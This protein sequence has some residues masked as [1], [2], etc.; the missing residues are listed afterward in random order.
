MIITRAQINH[1]YVLLFSLYFLF[2]IFSKYSFF[3]EALRS[4]FEIMKYA[5]AFIFMLKVF[6]YRT[7]LNFIQ[8]YKLL[9]ISLLLL[10][11]YSLFNLIIFSSIT[12]SNIF[13]AFLLP[14]VILSAMVISEKINDIFIY[15]KLLSIFLVI[16]TMVIV[17]SILFPEHLTYTHYGTNRVRYVFG[18][19]K[20]SYFAETLVL[21]VY[22]TI[23]L[24]M[25]TKEI[26]DQKKYKIILFIMFSLMIL[27]DSRS[28]L[29][30]MIVF[31]LTYKFFNIRYSLVKLFLIVLLFIG[32]LYSILDFNYK[33]IMD[34]G[35]GRFIWWD[36]AI[37]N[38]IHTLTEELFGTGY[39]NAITN[40][41]MLKY[42]GNT[43]SSFH[44]DSFF[45]ETFIQQGYIGLILTFLV[46]F[47]MSGVQRNKL[48]MPILN[49]MVVYGLFESVIFHFATLFSLLTWI[50]FFYKDN[51]YEN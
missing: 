13:L 48:S 16:F 21:L 20:P 43:G 23:F 33:D 1:M 26:K 2:Y 32:I 38:N 17:F 9:S 46:L 31:F 42:T 15:K 51:H 44:V 41:I 45:V 27:S 47:L 11:I 5:I 37:S 49:S 14:M 10:I 30:S 6:N 22:M 25:Y 35:S 50:I 3:S 40:Q 19:V 39:G 12:P 8:K 4:S 24:Y 34:W 18:F 7:I 29:L 28:A 36:M